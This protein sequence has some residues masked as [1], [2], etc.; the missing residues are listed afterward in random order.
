[1]CRK[2]KE[3][4]SV[5][6]GTERIWCTSRERGEG[7]GRGI[8][9]PL[10]SKSTRSVLSSP[11]TPDWTRR[12]PRFPIPPSSSSSSSSPPA[13]SYRQPSCRSTH[14]PSSSTARGWKTASRYTSMRLLKSA[15]LR[16]ATWGAKNMHFHIYKMEENA[17]SH[18][19][20]RNGKWR[21]PP[22]LPPT[23]TAKTRRTMRAKK[24]LTATNT[25]T[26]NSPGR[27]SDR[28]TSWHSG[29][30]GAIPSGDARTDLG[31]GTFSIRIG[32]NLF[33]AVTFRFI[34][35]IIRS[36]WFFFLAHK[37]K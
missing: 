25:L 29:T 33:F 23:R 15:L 11:S 17:Q 26:P 24:D 22:R 28:D 12:A 14:H 3:V 16:L 27:P 30:S 2:R 18:E 32:P 1:M 21:S 10:Y 5:V 7:G 36:F 8:S 34:G 20:H 37:G 35:Y 6:R 9:H 4:R 13:A 19:I 31:R